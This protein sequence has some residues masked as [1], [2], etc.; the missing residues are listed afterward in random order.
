MLAVPNRPQKVIGW[1]CSYQLW[2]PTRLDC[3]LP[4]KVFLQM[5]YTHRKPS[6]AQWKLFDPLFNIVY[7]KRSFLS[8]ES[9]T[10]RSYRVYI[11]PTM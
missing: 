2:H 5:K 4:I 10:S 7:G 8:R 3:I 9:D 1:S 6:S 11:S